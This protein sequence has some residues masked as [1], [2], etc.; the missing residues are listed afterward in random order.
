MFDKLKMITEYFYFGYNQNMKKIIILIVTISF[1][2]SLYVFSL[3]NKEYY[4]YVDN[5]LIED[6]KFNIIK[7]NIAVDAF[8]FMSAINGEVTYLADQN[9]VI[10]FASNCQTISRSNSDIAT[11]GGMTK[12]LP[13]N[14]FWQDDSYF[15]ALDFLA[16]AY[17]YEIFI[18]DDEIRLIKRDS[19]LFKV[20]ADTECESYDLQQLG[21]LVL[22]PYG[23]RYIRTEEGVYRY[24]IEDEYDN[25]GIAYQRYLKENLTLEQF[26][27]NL[28]TDLL[29]EELTVLSD[30]EN[31]RLGRFDYRHFNVESG[32]APHHILYDY[33]FIEH[34]NYFY[35]F[36]SRIEGE[37]NSYFSELCD[38]IL[39]EIEF[40]DTFYN[41]REHFY[42]YDDY[43]K[44]IINNN[45]LQ[46]NQEVFSYLPFEA[47]LAE[48]NNQLEFYAEV[49]KDDEVIKFD[50]HNKD[51]KLNSKIYTPFGI[52][53]HNIDIFVH[54]QGEP[55]KPLL[56]FSVLN[57]SDRLTKYLVPTIKINSA[58]ME[59]TSIADYF[60]NSS[61]NSYKRAEEIFE[62]I[63]QN[64]SLEE[65]TWLNDK[66]LKTANQV[67]LTKTGNSL[68]INFLMVAILRAV[69]ISARVVSGERD[70]EIF[71]ATEAQINGKWYVYDLY[72]AIKGKNLP[73]SLKSYR[74]INKEKYNTF[75]DDYKILK[76]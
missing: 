32:E 69:D 65:K 44:M 22:M 28:R 15:I 20:I 46:E 74:Y 55:Q 26:V 47:E 67:L 10:T 9:V 19:T 30:V 35:V 8:V 64:V 68:E 24:G 12:R 36:I 63:K 76:Y 11:I 14:P 2:V 72:S 37:K 61:S 21:L 51:G 71:Y 52:G 31:L 42:I 34:N 56:A 58:C 5:T 53:R 23:W 6:M 57:L 66:D 70:G 41:S 18:K 54:Y 38:Q 50:I 40:T 59:I 25:Y 45:H 1:I 29:N 3:D 43:F 75:F 16:S 27:I 73:Y 49:S 48:I 4:L 39:A 17:N 62:Y 60:I 7:D 33:Y 13:F